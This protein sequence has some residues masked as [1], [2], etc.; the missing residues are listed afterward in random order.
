MQND[1]SSLDT[2]KDNLLRAVDAEYNVMKAEVVLDIIC[3]LETMTITKDQL[4][5]T[6]L[7]REINTIRQKIDAKKKSIQQIDKSSELIIEIAQRAKKLLRSWQGLLNICTKDSS[8]ICTNG[9]TKPRLILKVKLHS[10][11]TKRKRQ[12]DNEIHSKRKKIQVIETSISSNLPHSKTTQELLIEMQQKIINESLHESIKK[13]HNKIQSTHVSKQ[14]A[15]S[16]NIHHLPG[17]STEMS[18]MSS[19]LTNTTSCSHATAIPILPEQNQSIES[20]VHEQSKLFSSYQTIADLMQ[21]H[22]RRVLAEHDSRELEARP[23]LLLVPIEQLAFVYERERTTHSNEMTPSKYSSITTIEKLNQ[24]S[25]LIALPFIDCPF[26]FD[27]ILD[28]L[29][30]QHPTINI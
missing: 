23:D 27:F 6:R 24:P 25:D 13:D 11:Q 20:T 4:Q 16:N 30:V 8:P 12:F 10:S 14:I 5:K 3:Q 28:E 9:E 26:E 7:G 29:V 15:S 18:S 2:L 21:D 1:S 17:S 19:S 22:R